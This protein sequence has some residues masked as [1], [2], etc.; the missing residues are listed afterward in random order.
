MTGR[1]DGKVAIVT[2]GASGIGAATCRLFLQEGAAVMIADI[3]P[4]SDDALVATIASAPDRAEYIKTDVSAEK[5]VAAAIAA[6]AA[7]WGKLDIA[8]A[9]A[10]IGPTGAVET[11]SEDAWDRIMSINTKGVFFVTKYSVLEMLK[12]GGGSIV[13]ISSTYAM[14]GAPGAAAYCASKGAVRTFTKAVALEHVSNRIRSNSIHPGVI[15]TPMITRGLAES[16]DADAMRALLVAQ[17]PGGE[18][19]TPEDIAWGCVYLA[20]DESRFVSGAELVIDQGMI[21]R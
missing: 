5:Q 3:E 21:A 7:R 18:M 1:L 20:S 8:V 14:V 16:D 6:A 12:N 10:G 4:P 2:G 9:C 19:G 15:E 17:Q 13:N 11:L